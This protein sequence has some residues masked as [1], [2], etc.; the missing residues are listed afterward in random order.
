MI[1]YLSKE[2][3]DELNNDFWHISYGVDEDG[4]DLYTDDD[5]IREI[6]E[7]YVGKLGVIEDEQGRVTG[8]ALAHPALTEEDEIFLTVLLEERVVA[9]AAIQ[10][11]PNKERAEARQALRVEL[12]TAARK[13]DRLEARRAARK[14]DRQ[15]A[16]Q[17]Y[18]QELRA[19]ARMASRLGT[20]AA[21]K[22]NL[23]FTTGL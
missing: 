7:A 22:A 15:T 14:A 12:R 19:D 21:A 23:D 5:D 6:P 10:A 16:R 8:Y 9:M 18:R 11:L 2:Q 4:V 1:I 3:G 13:D 20:L 17:Q